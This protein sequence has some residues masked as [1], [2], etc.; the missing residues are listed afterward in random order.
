MTLPPCAE[1]S[2][3]DCTPPLD[4]PTARPLV[5]GSL[6]THPVVSGILTR[7]R[8]VTDDPRDSR[9][10][11]GSRR[12]QYVDDCS[13]TVSLRRR[14]SDATLLLRFGRAAGDKRFWLRAHGLL[15]PEEKSLPPLAMVN[16]KVT[17][18]IEDQVAITRVEQ[19]F[20]NHTDRR[21]EATYVFPV[22]KGASVGKFS[23]WVNGKEVK[24]RTR[25][26]QASPPDLHRHRAPHPG[27][28][29]AGV[30]RQQ[31]ASDAGLPDPAARRSEGGAQLHQRRRT[32]WRL[33]EYIYPLK[34]DGKATATL[35]E[36]SIEATIK[37]QHARTER[38]QPHARHRRQAPADRQTS[39]RHFR[40]EPGT[41]R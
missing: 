5:T 21:L 25:R 2:A 3:V 36:F 31:P 18:T 30:S 8:I 20:R 17:I 19:T 33:V 23:M 15:I 35:E 13:L 38:L 29:P 41:A 4:A 12:H 27:S 6:H 34:T 22:P 11:T 1:I 14:V 10:G 7:A 40:E 16:H 9:R 39:D 24:R 37:S 28:R 26:G 32:G